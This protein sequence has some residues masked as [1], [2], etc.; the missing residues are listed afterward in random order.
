MVSVKEAWEQAKQRVNPEGLAISNIL[1]GSSILIIPPLQAALTY[2]I[3]ELSGEVPTDIVKLL[4]I[5]ILGCINV[6]SIYAETRTLN[7]ER[8]SASPIA[9]TLNVAIGNPS[10]ASLLGHGINFMMSY[11]LNPINLLSI[12]SLVGGDQGKLFAENAVGV[13]I[14]L[15]SWNIGFNTL[16]STHRVEPVVNGMRNIRHKILG[17]FKM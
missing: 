6:A 4:S 15:G 17:Q 12:G 13:G 8:Y 14:A 9:S 7:Q 3:H 11:G 1:T 2:A 10:V 16:I 5:G